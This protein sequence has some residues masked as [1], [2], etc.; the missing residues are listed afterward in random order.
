MVPSG[1]CA[2]HAASRVRFV[3]KH[4]RFVSP[5][6]LSQEAHVRSNRGLLNLT[7]RLY[8][9]AP[10]TAAALPSHATNNHLSLD[11]SSYISI[12]EAPSVVCSPLPPSDTA[13]RHHEIFDEHQPHLSHLGI[14]DDDSPKS[15]RRPP[16]G[17]E[18]RPARR[19]RP[20]PGHDRGCGGRASPDSGQISQHT[21]PFTPE[22]L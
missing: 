7:L 2:T 9:V 19:R 4:A 22:L 18:A 8:I 21:R 12:Y 10:G 3:S 15:E 6:N 1:R 11:S 16:A 17:L 5:F 13:L 20:S 14:F